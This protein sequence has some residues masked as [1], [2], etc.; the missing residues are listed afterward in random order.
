MTTSPG[1]AATSIEAQASFEELPANRPHRQHERK[2][3][4]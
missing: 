1:L 3:R 4:R 2:T